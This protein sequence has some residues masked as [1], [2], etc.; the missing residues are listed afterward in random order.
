MEWLLPE[1]TLLLEKTV[2]TEIKY[3]KHWIALRA[4]KAICNKI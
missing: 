1:S 4:K 2:L 3:A